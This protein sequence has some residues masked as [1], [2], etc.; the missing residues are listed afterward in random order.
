MWSKATE[1]HSE[2]S[3]DTIPDVEFLEAFDRVRSD[4]DKIPSK[5]LEPVRLNTEE[6]TARGMRAADNAHRDRYRF[7]ETYA[8]PPLEEI[9]WLRARAMAVKGAELSATKH[10]SQSDDGRDYVLRAMALLEETYSVVRDY[11]AVIYRKNL[12][13]WRED[14]PSLCSRSRD[15]RGNAC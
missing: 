10:E 4:L 8:E 9:D 6:A 12:D 1:D 7:E 5:D 14:Y 2:P 3:L 11:A 15:P 13:Q